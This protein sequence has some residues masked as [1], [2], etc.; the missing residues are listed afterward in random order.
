MICAV[1]IFTV[2]DFGWEMKKNVTDNSLADGINLI[3]IGKNAYE[4]IKLRFVLLLNVFKLISFIIMDFL[5]EIIFVVKKAFSQDNQQKI[6]GI[7]N[8]SKVK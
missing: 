1:I 5:S 8:P 4:S 7:S 3:Y 2:T 6:L